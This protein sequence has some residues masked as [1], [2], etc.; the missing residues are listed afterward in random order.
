VIAT[1][2]ELEARDAADIADGDAFAQPARHG[3]ELDAPEL[4]HRTK[5]LDH[6]I[7]HPSR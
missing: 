3:V 2:R 1:E 5:R 4:K 7:V 6:R